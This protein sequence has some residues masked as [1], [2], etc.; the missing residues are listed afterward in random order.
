MIIYFYLV[1]FSCS[2]SHSVL[3]FHYVS[4]FLSLFVVVVVVLSQAFF[5][6]SRKAFGYI[7]VYSMYNIMHILENL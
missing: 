3:P 6:S 5:K 1:C 2:V 4:Q 7:C